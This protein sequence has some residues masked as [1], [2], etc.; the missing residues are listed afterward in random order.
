MH[1]R[2]GMTQG[3]PLALATYN[4]GLL[5]P[6]KNLKTEFSDISQPWY[7]DDTCALEKF[8]R[9]KAYCVLLEGH[10]QGRG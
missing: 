5:P 7:T 6:I 4:I 3:G 9:V 8:I 10:S 1:S 2:E